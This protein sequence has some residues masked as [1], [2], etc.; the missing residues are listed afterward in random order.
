M[1]IMIKGVYGI[2][3]LVQQNY[4]HLTLISHHEVRPPSLGWRGDTKLRHQQPFKPDISFQLE[5]DSIKCYAFFLRIATSA[6]K[7]LVKLPVVH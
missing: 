6:F 3:G 5:S 7:D 1:C 2:Y 4:S